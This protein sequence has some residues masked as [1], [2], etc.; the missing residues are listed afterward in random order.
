MA[1][2]V[3]SV[4]GLSKRYAL[5]QRGLATTNFR[6]RLGELARSPFSF[7]GG[8]KEPAEVLWSLKDVSFEVAQGEVVGLVGRNGA[9]KSTMLKILS[10]ITEPTEGRIELRGKVGSLLEVGTGFHPELSGREN[11]YLNGAILGMKRTEI[12]RVFD[13]IVAFSEIEKFIDTPVK[14]YSSGMYMRLAFSVAAHLETDILLVDEVLAVGDLEFQKKCLGKMQQVTRAGRTV[15]FVSHN[16]GAVKSLCSH[17]VLLEKGRM[18]MAGEVEPVLERYLQTN[19]GMAQTGEIPDD[20]PRPFGTLEAKFRSVA[21]ADVEGNPT[22]ELY[23]EQ[24]FEVQT[25]FEVLKPLE[26]AI[27]EISVMTPDGTQVLYASNV[28]NGGSGLTCGTGPRT[29]AVRMDVNLLPRQ[30]SLL[31]GLHHSDGTTIDWI[32][33]A[34]DFT[35]L[36]V[37]RT[38]DDYYRWSSVR[39]Y[40]KPV[41]QWRTAGPGAIS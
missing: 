8:G 33:R 34:L 31:L 26:N 23:Y 40:V 4:R 25:T 36:N 1:A 30:Y 13:E 38:S 17:A 16:L 5:G 7:F 20:F 22:G 27:V 39:G 12:A 18:L 3:I 19:D 9:G 10:R 15:I 35:V 11:I 41:T 28:D 14:F 2:P 24:S 29:I 6:E 37:S 32:E 21:L